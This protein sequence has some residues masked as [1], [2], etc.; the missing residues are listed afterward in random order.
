VCATT[1]K[2]L[3]SWEISAFFIPET[4]ASYGR[5]LFKLTELTDQH[6]HSIFYFLAEFA[7]TL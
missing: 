4:K 1:I 6:K 2:Q 3:F 5:G 7:S